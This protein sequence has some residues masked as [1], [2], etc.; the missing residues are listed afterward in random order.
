[1]RLSIERCG[2]PHAILLAIFCMLTGCE[3]RPDDAVRK[4]LSH[5][6]L[7]TSL[8]VKASGHL[9]HSPKDEAEF[10]QAIADS[11]VKLENLRV[12]SIDELFVSER[13]GKPLVVIYGN[14]LPTSGAI[15]YEKEGVNGKR[16][17]G[18]TIG[19]VDE[20]DE[21][22]LNELIPTSMQPN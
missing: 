8:Y 16:E 20:V 17:V 6:R 5:I 22:K 19:R 3:S 13:D 1:V 12:N 11:D 14:R 4:E 15:V 2:A 21:A 7:L 10:K 18:F 9:G